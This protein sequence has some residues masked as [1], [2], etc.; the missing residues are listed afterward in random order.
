MDNE[1][2]LDV[3]QEVAGNTQNQNDNQNADQKEEM[4]PVRDA[5]YYYELRHKGKKQSS[6]DDVQDDDFY[7]K[8]NR[9]VDQRVGAVKDSIDTQARTVEL[10]EF[11]ENNPEF[12]EF[13]PKIA[14]W[15]SDPSRRHLP[16]GTIA[17]EAV[18]TENLRKIYMEQGKQYAKEV[19]AS[20]T[21]GG[22]SARNLGEVKVSKEQI[23]SMSPK[24]LNDFIRKQSH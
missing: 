23:N 12:K 14:K 19:S 21:F 17:L 7:M 13:S 22:S 24:E 8:V 6:D 15:W 10:K 18:G 11:I 4:P 3:N 2:D 1:K 20:R 16:V 5:S 9:I